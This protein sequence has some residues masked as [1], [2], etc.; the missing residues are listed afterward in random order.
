MSHERLEKVKQ[1]YLVTLAASVC[2][3]VIAATT[4]L[5][6]LRGTKLDTLP[7]A[8]FAAFIVTAVGVASQKYFLLTLKKI[9]FVVIF[10]AV[11]CASFILLDYDCFPFAFG[12]LAIFLLSFRFHD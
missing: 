6:W 8:L 11:P 9:S 2:G 5:H 4:S 12:P 10:Q 1:D 7:H 3:I